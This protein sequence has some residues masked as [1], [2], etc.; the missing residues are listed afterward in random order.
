MRRMQRNKAIQGCWWEC[1]HSYAGISL[2][3]P[4]R[5]FWFCFKFFRVFCFIL[6]VFVCLRFVLAT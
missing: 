6:F 1:G 5:V 3:F 4:L 2:L